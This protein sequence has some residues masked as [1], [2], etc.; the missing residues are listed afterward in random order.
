MKNK[1]LWSLIVI[2]A[3][4]AIVFAF[5]DL[6][7]S[8]AI[9]DPT[10]GWAKFLETYG[11]IPGGLVAFGCGAILLRLYKTQKQFGSILGLV[12]LYLVTFLAASMALMDAFG[13]QQK[14]HLNLPLIFGLALVLLALV[15]VV[16]GRIPTEKLAQF[17]PAAKVGLTLLFAASILTVWTFKIPFGRW[18]FR[19]MLAEGGTSLFTPWYLPQGS[20]GHHSFFSGH[21]AFFFSVLPVILFFKIQTTGRKVAIML[22]LLWGIVGILSRI[23]IGAH[24][25]SDVLFGAGETILW[26]ILLSKWFKAD[27]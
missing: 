11:Q 2:W 15:R 26:F 4:L 22:V 19:D 5:F 23:V 1:A 18:T 10:A 14:A 17:K 27:L 20:N 9:F 7:I 25:A 21:A 12:G 8:Q 13:A 24:F 3:L 16:L 6:Q